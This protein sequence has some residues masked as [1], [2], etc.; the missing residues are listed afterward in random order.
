MK[1]LL[2]LSF[3][4]RVT[5]WYLN[6][7]SMGKSQ[8]TPLLAAGGNGL[9]SPAYGCV[10]PRLAFSLESPLDES[11]G[12]AREIKLKSFPS[13]APG[14]FTGKVKAYQ[15]VKKLLMPL[16]FLIL[17]FFASDRTSANE[18][19][20]EDPSKKGLALTGS[21]PGDVELV[22]A[23]W[24][25]VYSVWDVGLNY[26]SY[27]PMLYD[28]T[29]DPLL[30][31]GWSGEVL[32][33]NEPVLQNI[34]PVLG[35]GRYLELLD[36]YPNAKFIVGG[37]VEASTEWARE[38]L[39]YIDEEDYPERWA[40]HHYYAYDE[41]LAIQNIMNFYELVKTPLWVTEFGSITADHEANERFIGWLEDQQWIE[42]F[43]Y[44]PTRM[45]K[46]CPWFPDHWSDDMS[47][48][49]WGSGEIMPMGE[50]YRDFEDS[51]DFELHQLFFPLMINN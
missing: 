4:S 28:G 35:A 37:T 49:D 24:W 33:F 42:R 45:D 50:I 23:D 8:G 20:P 51:Q 13:E 9:A 27:V 26:S 11:G 30:P 46:D 40:V 15:I 10:K 36:E 3:S 31:S 19:P 17:A 43:A 16:V 18:I 25:Y 34:E 22:Q 38:F 7:R 12:Q 48:I 41:T 14:R 29:P 44:F 21:Q 1:L 32:V 39:V 2:I 47:L 5:D 6:A